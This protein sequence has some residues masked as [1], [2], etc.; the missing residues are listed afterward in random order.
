[1]QAWEAFQKTEEFANAE[2]WAKV[3]QL[4]ISP[5]GSPE[6]GL[7]ARYPHLQ[8]SLWALFMG[9]WIAAGGKIDD[10]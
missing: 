10:K 4:Q 2:K 7:Q 1:M 6:S 8:G 3:V 5:D 9:G